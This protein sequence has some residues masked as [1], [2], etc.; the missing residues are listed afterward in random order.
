MVGIGFANNTAE[1]FKQYPKNQIT[2]KNKII[3]LA[4]IAVAS[5]ALAQTVQA[6]PIT[7]VIGFTGTYAQVGGDNGT[8]NTATSFTLSDVSIVQSQTLGSFANGSL[9]NFISS[10]SLTPATSLLPNVQ[11][12][13][14]LAGGTT[15]TFTV[16]TESLVNDAATSVSFTGTGTISDNNNDT[17][18]GTY[19]LGFT[20]A[21]G[22]GDVS[23]TFTGNSGT[24]TVPDGGTTVLLLGAALSGLALVKRKM[25][26]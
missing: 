4:G 14:V 20:D 6:N 23:F 2:M 26:A 17:T 15:Y 18:G 10:V 11:L 12:W 1:D 8:L 13:Q 19:T 22:G 25:T 16:N 21:V 3:K 24:S 9:V 7:G 5:V